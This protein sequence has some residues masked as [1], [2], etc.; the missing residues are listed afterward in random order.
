MTPFGSSWGF[1]ATLGRTT[2]VGKLG[3]NGNQTP[4]HL[5]GSQ[6]T[7]WRFPGQSALGYEGMSEYQLGHGE[8][9]EIRPPSKLIR[10]AHT[11]IHP[12]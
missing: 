3:N 8:H 1:S 2:P 4:A 12:V 6:R 5:L 9:D 10:G 11:Q 7:M